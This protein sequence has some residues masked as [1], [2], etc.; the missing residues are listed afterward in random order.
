[1]ENIIDIKLK[2]LEGKGYGE[3]TTQLQKGIKLTY[4]NLSPIDKI[5]SFGKRVKHEIPQKKLSYIQELESRKNIET[6]LNQLEK[7]FGGNTPEQYSNLSRG[8]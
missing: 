5:M 4:I 1:M 2:E 3:H 7:D 6:M 8:N